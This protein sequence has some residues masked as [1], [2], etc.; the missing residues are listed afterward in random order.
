MYNNFNL[1]NVSIIILNWNGWKDTVE[2]L[3]SLY[4]INYPNYEIIVIDNNSEDDSIEKIKEYCNG[5]LKV[6][7][8]FFEYTPKNKPIK[9][10]EYSQDVNKHPKLVN[11]FKKLSCNRKLMIIKND[12]NYGFAEGNNIGIRFALKNLDPDYIMLLNNDT[13]VERNFLGEMIQIAESKKNIG[14][15]GPKIYYYDFKGKK[16]VLDFAGGKINMWIGKPQHIGINEVDKKQYDSLRKVDYIN[17]AC[18]LAKKEM[19]NKVGLL[20][21]IYFLYWEE[22]DWCYRAHQLGFESFYTPKAQIWHKTAVSIKTSG[23]G[24]YYMIRNKIIFMK[25]YANKPQFI[26]FL[27]YLFSIQFWVNIKHLIVQKKLKKVKLYFKG[28]YN[29]FLS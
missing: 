10:F 21:P 11:E 18:M 14:F 1:I 27:V 13:V 2:C 28:I 5:K 29:G 20:D 8:E 16:N 25:K 4:Q 22:N 9:V 26:T 7:S 24:E 15:V 23:L 12:S 17:G 6:K 3:E 19:L